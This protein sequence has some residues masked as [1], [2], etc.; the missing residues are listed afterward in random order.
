MILLNFVVEQNMIT[1][2]DNTR[3]QT[4]LQYM[5]INE[6]TTADIKGHHE[7]CAFYWRDFIGSI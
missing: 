4:V 5:G 3:I 6:L 7:I 2:Y 1:E